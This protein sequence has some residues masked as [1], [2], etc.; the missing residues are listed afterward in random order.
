LLDVF[1]LEVS[2][3]IDPH[4]SISAEVASFHPVALPPSAGKTILAVALGT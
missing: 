2:G 3:A 1:K 4:V